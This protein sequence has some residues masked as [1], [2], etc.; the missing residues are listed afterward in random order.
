MNTAHEY[1]TVKL[2]MNNPQSYWCMLFDCFRLSD[3]SNMSE[4][5]R[6]RSPSK[7]HNMPPID[8]EKR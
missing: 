7:Q 4:S 2:H 5:H 8:T 3:N 1:H 6:V